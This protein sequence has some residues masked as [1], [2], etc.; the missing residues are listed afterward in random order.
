MLAL[1][2]THI[3]TANEVLEKLGERIHEHVAQ[4]AQQ[5]L[6]CSVA[7]QLAGQIGINAMEQRKQVKESPDCFRLGTVNWIV[8]G[9]RMFACMFNLRH[10]RT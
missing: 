5:I 7:G 9:G 3:R 4:S 2:A 10:A 1:A 8:N 6:P